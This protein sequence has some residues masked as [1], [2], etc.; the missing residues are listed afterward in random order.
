MGNTFSCSSES[1]DTSCS[2]IFASCK[3]DHCASSCSKVVADVTPA[4]VA[5]E[6]VAE[7]IVKKYIEDHLHTFLAEHVPNIMAAQLDAVA[8]ATLN[9]ITG[10]APQPEIVVQPTV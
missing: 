8:A 10:A 4:V 1:S 3:N 2:S 6:H 5:L 7:T 9:S